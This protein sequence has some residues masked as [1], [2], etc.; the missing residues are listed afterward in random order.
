M[1]VCVCVHIKG[2]RNGDNP[3]PGMDSCSCFTAKFVQWCVDG[4]EMEA[5]SV[6]WHPRDGAG[7]HAHVCLLWMVSEEKELFASV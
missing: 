1:C 7:N 3:H 5:W 2:T 4:E 6:A